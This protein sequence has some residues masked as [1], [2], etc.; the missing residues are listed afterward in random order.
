MSHHSSLI[1][2]IMKNIISK[3]RAIE[4]I[5][6]L[7]FQEIISNVTEQNPESQFHSMD[8][9]LDLSDGSIFY[10]VMGNN[11]SFQ[12]DHFICLFSQPGNYRVEIPDDEIAGD[13]DI[14][15]GGVEEFSDYDERVL[16]CVI[17]YAMEGRDVTH[18]VYQRIE[19]IYFRR[20]MREAN[21][22]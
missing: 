8:C 4:I 20:M 18:D 21:Y 16:N 11:E 15:D 5:E 13:D 22:E 1:L 17:W 12:D 3:E 19:N 10:R 9:Y 6:G 2:L 14:P 7:D